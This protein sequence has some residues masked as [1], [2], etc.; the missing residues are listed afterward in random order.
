[1]H[2]EE[3]TMQD[4]RSSLKINTVETEVGYRQL[5]WLGHLARMDDDRLEKKILFSYLED[6]QPFRPRK[7]SLT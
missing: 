6:E 1:M 3:T 4:I 2:D 5:R 7:R